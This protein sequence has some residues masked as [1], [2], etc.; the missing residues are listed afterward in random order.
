MKRL[1]GW[2]GAVGREGAE[3]VIA[4][5]GVEGITT[6]SRLQACLPDLVPTADA[7][8]NEQMSLPQTSSGCCAPAYCGGITEIGTGCTARKAMMLQAA[9]VRRLGSSKNSGGSLSV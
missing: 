3:V 8:C 6:M 9:S 4:A 5:A 2:P 1:G 7:S